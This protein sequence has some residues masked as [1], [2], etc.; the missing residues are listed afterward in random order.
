MAQATLLQGD[1]TRGGLQQPREQA[2]HVL[3]AQSGFGLTV[4][5]IFTI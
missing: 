3:A 5:V 4:R 2:F 1:L